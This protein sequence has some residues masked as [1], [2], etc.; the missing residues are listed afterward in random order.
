MSEFRPAAA[1][2]ALMAVI[3]AAATVVAM[4]LAAASDA[5][6][7]A[8][9]AAAIL[10]SVM[11]IA[12]WQ[13]S[14]IAAGAVPS[15]GPSATATELAR[16]HARLLA[17]TYAWGGLAILAGYYLTPLFWH[18]AWQYGGAMV[19]VGAGLVTYSVSEAGAFA[20]RR[21][22][23]AQWLAGAQAIMATGGVMFLIAS[24]KLA[25][26]KSDWMANIVFVAGG[27]AI[28]A[29]SVMVIT[30]QRRLRR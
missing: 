28:V 14:R 15:D 26:G 4:A 2:W 10:A 13:V 9:G 24:G 5:R 29:L 23:A 16:W 19:I 20:R 12:G 25:V 22:E 7:A 3:A 27:L 18:H 6:A 17:L 8:F 1:R 11:I 30:G 21:L